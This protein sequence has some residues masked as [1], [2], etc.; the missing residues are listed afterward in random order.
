MKL[1]SNTL[2]CEFKRILLSPLYTIAIFGYVGVTLLTLIE[3]G[4]D[5][6][7][8]LTSIYYIY[9]II[10]YL[11]FHVLYI[12]FA[13]IPSTLLFC[14]DWENQFIRFVVIRSSKR[15]YIYTKVVA[16]FV[17]AASVVI[18]SNALLFLILG[19]QYP[20]CNSL[21]D[22]LPNGYLAWPGNNGVLIY[23]LI[24]VLCEAACAGFL[25]VTAMWV[26][27]IVVSSFVAL[28]AP[29]VVYYMVSTTSYFFQ[30]PVNLHINSL[31][32]GLVEINSNPILSLLYTLVVFII[33]TIVSGCFFANN[34]VR[35]I[36]NG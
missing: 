30:L 25:C 35:R 24:K 17:T 27:T 4:T 11:D 10:R 14:S 28:A 36:Q 16:C 23:I 5:F 6:R 15:C 2:I 20:V 22:I 21:S 12:V 18:L 32:K 31:S 29:M 34:C 7:T 1:F 26:S 8:G 13:A 9:T 19:T 3:E 33:A